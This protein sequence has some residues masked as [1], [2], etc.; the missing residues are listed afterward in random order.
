MIPFIIGLN[1]FS[2][3]DSFFDCL[4]FSRHLMLLVFL[5]F[6]F[7][8][9][10]VNSRLNQLLRCGHLF[11][12]FKEVFEAFFVGGEGFGAVEAVDG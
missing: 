10:N 1:V 5:H 6:I 7:Q 3:K 11:V 2:V 8:S 9:F 4:V 12:E